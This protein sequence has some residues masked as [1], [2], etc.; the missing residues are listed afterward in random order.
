M[1]QKLP[2]LQGTP[3]SHTLIFRG[4]QKL[5]RAFDRPEVLLTRIEDNSFIGLSA[6]VEALQETKI[7]TQNGQ[8]TEFYRILNVWKTLGTI[9]QG[10]YCRFS[11]TNS[12]TC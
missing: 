9:N 7:H 10:K 12:R 6:V 1:Y 2:P 11:S 5:F 4:C 8:D 3:Q